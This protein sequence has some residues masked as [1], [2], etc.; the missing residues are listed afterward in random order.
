LFAEKKDREEEKGEREREER[1]SARCIS[2]CYKTAN[3][4]KTPP[5]SPNL[6]TKQRTTQEKEVYTRLRTKKN[7][8]KFA[9]GLGFRV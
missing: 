1:E 4:I 8:F 6:L 2:L 5:P 9:L 7:G 3:H